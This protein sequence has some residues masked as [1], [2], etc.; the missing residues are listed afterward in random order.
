MR[1]EF[2][3]GHL[4]W[5]EVGRIGRQIKECRTC[6]FDRLPDAGDFMHREIVHDDDVAALECWNKE[7]LHISQKHRPIH[8]ALK[9]ERCGHPAHAQAGHKGDCF[10]M[11]MRR[12]ADQSLAA[13]TDRDRLPDA[14]D[15]MHRE[16]VHDDDVAALE[17][18]NKELLHISQK[19]RPIHSALKYERCGHPAH[20]QA[21]H[22]GDCFPMSM[23][24]VADQ[25][26]AAWTD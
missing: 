14:G 21:G 26:L 6:C 7:L 1:L 16:I 17:C 12:V 2:A 4:D 9:Y 20:A 5:V 22:K 15:F 23:R 3:E 10:P 18:W 8:S 11:S 25:S 13:W 24:R 19:H